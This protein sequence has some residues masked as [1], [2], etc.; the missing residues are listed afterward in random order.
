MG[1]QNSMEFVKDY[2]DRMDDYEKQLFMRALCMSLE[3]EEI[4]DCMLGVWDKDE[5]LEFESCYIQMRED[6]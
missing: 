2:V 6:L 1:Q 3:H 5:Q 4:V